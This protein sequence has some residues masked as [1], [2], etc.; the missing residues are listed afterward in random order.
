MIV[1]TTS[2]HCLGAILLFSL[3]LSGVCD[4]S[5]EKYSARP[6]FI[7]DLR[8]HEYHQRCLDFRN[9]SDEV[10]VYKRQKNSFLLSGLK[11]VCTFV[12]GA[13]G[14]IAKTVNEEL[15]FDDKYDYGLY[16]GSTPIIDN[17]LYAYVSELEQQT[18]QMVA[19]LS[20]YSSLASFTHSFIYIGAG[21]L[22]VP[23]SLDQL[24]ISNMVGLWGIRV[25]IRGAGYELTGQLERLSGSRYFVGYAVSAVYCMPVV[26]SSTFWPGNAFLQIYTNMGCA[27]ASSQFQSIRLRHL[28]AQGL[29][30]EKAL[31]IC[32]GESFMTAVLII[33]LQS[34]LG[35]GFLPLLGVGRL[36]KV[37]TDCVLIK[38]KKQLLPDEGVTRFV[39]EYSLEGA[40]LIIS[41]TINLW[42]EGVFVRLFSNKMRDNVLFYAGT[43][44]TQ[45]AAAVLL[46]LLEL[47]LSVWSG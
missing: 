8:W 19:E 20:G 16:K 28:Q 18:G 33:G 44:L 3:S 9:Y 25:G 22:F 6:G 42:S 11:P 47:V 17:L 5:V 7:S 26:V 40:A 13:I 39:L 41:V 2:F 37:C 45:Q 14:A 46:L 32:A 36:L 21:S 29:S 30:E 31:G 35:G 4:H 10:V 12:V 1:R 15:G 24:Y 38:A 23:D 34:R 43:R 27:H